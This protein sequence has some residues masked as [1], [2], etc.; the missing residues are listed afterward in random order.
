[1]WFSGPCSLHWFYPAGFRLCHGSPGE[2]W[3]MEP[4]LGTK[5]ESWRDLAHGGPVLMWHRFS[6]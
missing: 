5:A 6:A 2:A 4:V 1:M 3:L